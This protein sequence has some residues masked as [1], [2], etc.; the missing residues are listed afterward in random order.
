MPETRKIESDFLNENT[1]Y[2]HC[3][4]K[5]LTESFSISQIAL[6]VVYVAP[7]EDVLNKILN[8]MGYNVPHQLLFVIALKRRRPFYDYY[9]IRKYV[10]SDIINISIKIFNFP[11]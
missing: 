5:D 6:F 2:T 3:T 7:P 10:L 11:W 1:L 4:R 8:K 9:L